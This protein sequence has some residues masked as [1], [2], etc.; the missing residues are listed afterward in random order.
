MHI[1]IP[2]PPLHYFKTIV[3]HTN[4]KAIMAPKF[5]SEDDQFVM[6]REKFDEALKHHQ[7]KT[8]TILNDGNCFFRAISDQLYG[9]QDA[10]LELR[11]EAVRYM[12]AH[13]QDFQPFIVGGSGA[14]GELR[15]NNGRS[16]KNTKGGSFFDTLSQ[17]DRDRISKASFEKYIARMSTIGQW[18]GELEM[19]ATAESIGIH[20]TILKKPCRA[21]SKTMLDDLVYTCSR[22]NVL[23]KTAKII[24]HEWRHFS[25]VR[26]MFPQFGTFRGLRPQTM[27]AG[28][29]NNEAKPIS[30]PN[31]ASVVFALQA[32]T[33]E[34]SGAAHG[35]APPPSQG[36]VSATKP[37]TS[38]PKL[39]TPPYTPGCTPS[40][41]HKNP[42]PSNNTSKPSSAGS[43]SPKA[44]P[45]PIT[46]K[47]SSPAGISKPKPRPKSKTVVTTG[48]CK[49]LYPGEPKPMTRTAMRMKC[50]MFGRD[51][52]K[53]FK[54]VR[55]NADGS[56]KTFPG[57]QNITI[58]KAS[59]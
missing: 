2:T 11:M 4:Q 49:Y 37:Q 47:L 43:A 21:S 50:G 20:I 48:E 53:L 12:Q 40:P 16:T 7:L 17:E 57:D 51:E 34:I 25:S 45:K 28:P 19:R 6:I 1:L 41:T 10:H 38:K 30:H 42:K 5:I 24:H 39:P 3:F 22:S 36:G 31:A 54:R 14:E 46:S 27:D 52:G 44:N 8:H 26:P 15:R 9:H 58:Y 18:A 29:S 32:P 35:D 23:T 59:A 55:K 56:E 33:H 13:A